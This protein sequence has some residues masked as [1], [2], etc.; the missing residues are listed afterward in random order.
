MRTTISKDG[1]V[2]AF[3]TVGN[4]PALI[5]VDG[6]LC[7]RGFGPMPKLSALLSK[8]F[9]VYYYDRRGRGES[10]DRQPYGPDR[11]VEDLEAL[12]R[13][14]GGRAFVFGISS[15][16]ALALRAAERKL[17]IPK[18]ALYE[19]P[20]V[21]TR[22]N[23]ALSPDH[24]SKLKDI[25]TTGDRG[26][27][28]NYFMT[29]MVGV[30][31][32][33]AFIFRLMPVW[34]KL[35]AVAHTLPYDAAVMGDFTVPVARIHSIAVPALV[36]GGAKSPA[37]LRNAVQGVADALSN[38]TVRFLEGQTHNVKAEVLAPVLTEYFQRS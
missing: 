24:E 26:R 13:E 16:A 6:A 37:T 4:G 3:D 5:L 21:F 32:F 28:V 22:T 27:A 8:H 1:T 38:P 11:E 18:L 19:P 33:V 36:A 29:S 10:T 9:T 14:A 34:K 23:G 20:Y 35:K 7:H 12:I 31:G 15:G 17:N 2:I 30:P 25:L